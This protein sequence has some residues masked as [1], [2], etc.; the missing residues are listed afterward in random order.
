MRLWASTTLTPVFKPK[1]YTTFVAILI[2]FAGAASALFA[3]ITST[4][5]QRD[6]LVSRSQTIASILS[7]SDITALQGGVQDFENPSFVHI[8]G[9][10]EQIRTT[11]A[12]IE[13]LHLFV[14]KESIIK[15]AVDGKVSDK[16][17]EIQPGTNYYMTSPA[18]SRS[19]SKAEGSYDL[20]TSDNYGRWVG[21]YTPVVDRST[22]KTVGVVGVFVDA[23]TFYTEIALYALVLL[24][25]ASIPLAG[26]IRDIKIQS[27]EHEIL[28]LKN[29][30]VS[31]ASHELR[32]PLTGMLWGIHT[33]R[34]NKHATKAEQTLLD[35]MY[36]SA[37]SSLTTIN[38]IL[39]MS[40]FERGQAHK[41][42]RDEF[43]LLAVISQVVATMNLAAK[44][45]HIAIKLDKKSPTTALIV[46]DVGA[47]KRG[48]M[49]LV[50]NAV[51][52]ST[53]GSAVTI[54]CRKATTHEYII[55]VTDHGIGI[56]PEEQEKV[57]E[58]Y[59][60]AT[61]TSEMQANGTGLGLWI[62]KK[63]VE[64]HGGRLWINSE[65]NKG[66]T[67]SIALPSR[68]Q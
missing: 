28:Q 48:L 52:Y 15:V 16:I 57:L 62:T 37:E 42:H 55:T 29:Q 44:E 1:R 53:D 66:T 46:G 56:P 54:G 50:A 35:D 65:V 47:I 34:G 33:L 12:D 8:R 3:A 41:L 59:Y 36:K 51:K 61:N 22:G 6:A 21:A 11:S 17:D 25:L 30:F 7:V 49:N 43:D 10:L 63:I 60:R 32:S 23:P 58:G 18:L 26:I 4:V 68:Q 67:V 27:K 64:E 13:R 19:F 5:Q 14:I 20:L 24:L 2:V 31:I 40:I 38:E 45:K 39:D 9:Q